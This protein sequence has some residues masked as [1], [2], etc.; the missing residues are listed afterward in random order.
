MAAT[1]TQERT[2]ATVAGATEA[3]TSADVAE[4]LG[5]GRSTITK[6]LSDLERE[7]RVT[8]EPGG[9]EGGRR[10]PDRWTVAA[11]DGKKGRATSPSGRL[12]PG[13]LRDA[14]LDFVC[15]RPEEEL[16]PTQVAK[17]LDRSAGAVG[18]ALTR[19]AEAGSVHQ[20][21]ERPRRFTAAT[22]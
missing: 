17:A 1:D 12:R 9:R 22:N 19:L 15:A 3:L 14:V 16:S 13:Q 2:L 7:G 18:N 21:S 6:A 10:L 5:M 4:A 11:G 8:R 20:T